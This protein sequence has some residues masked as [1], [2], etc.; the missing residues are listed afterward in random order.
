MS[1]IK[2]DQD[3]VNVLQTE[4]KETNVITSLKKN[5]IA[6]CTITVYAIAT[7]VAAAVC[8]LRTKKVPPNEAPVKKVL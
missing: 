7:I 3:Y 1:S 6:Y 2:I 5:S 4:N 8:P